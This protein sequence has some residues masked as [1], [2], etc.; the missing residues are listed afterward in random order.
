MKK[1]RFKELEPK[2]KKY[3]KIHGNILSGKNLNDFQEAIGFIDLN[4]CLEFLFVV[5]GAE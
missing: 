3:L 1:S 5:I 4:E 2:I